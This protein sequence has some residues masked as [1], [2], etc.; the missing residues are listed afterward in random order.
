MDGQGIADEGELFLAA[1]QLALDVDFDKI[2]LGIPADK[3][4]IVGRDAFRDPST[5]G[6]PRPIAEADMTRI[7][8][9]ARTGDL[10]AAAG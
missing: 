2:F 4:A 7:F 6:N 9:A 8:L 5:G 1:S 3:A 10:K